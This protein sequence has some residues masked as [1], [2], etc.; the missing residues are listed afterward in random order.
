ML[1]KSSFTQSNIYFFTR[2]KKIRFDIPNCKLVDKRNLEVTL[3]IGGKVTLK[4]HKSLFEVIPFF[5]EIFKTEEDFLICFND[6]DG[7]FECKISYEASTPD[8]LVFNVFIKGEQQSEFTLLP[9]HFETE[10]ELEKSNSPEVVYVGQSFNMLTRMHSHKT[11]HRAS[12]KLQDNEEIRLYFITFRYAYGG[13]KG[14]FSFSNK[15]YNVMLTLPDTHPEEYYMKISLAE[16]FLIHFLQPIYNDQHKNTSI[17]KDTLVKEILLKFQVD[18]V[19]INFGVHGQYFQ[20]WSDNQKLK[21]DYV[22][23]DFRNI[24]QGYVEGHLDF[25]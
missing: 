23:L 25:W 12:S 3:T 14:K 5:R 6:E 1:E 2:V 11:L 19:I 15:P 20:F 18:G 17:E 9:E 24:E 21:T 7:W 10:D 8:R 22:S 4:V 16:R 13:S